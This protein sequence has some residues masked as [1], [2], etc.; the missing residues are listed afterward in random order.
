MNLFHLKERKG[1]RFLSSLLKIVSQNIVIFVSRTPFA[2]GPEDTPTMILQRIGE[3]SIS[4]SGGTWDN[5]TDIAK[6]HILLLLSSK[7]YRSFMDCIIL[8]TLDAI[9]QLWT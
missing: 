3:G 8:G 6:V 4:L 2:T 7:D 9:F 5:V 1:P